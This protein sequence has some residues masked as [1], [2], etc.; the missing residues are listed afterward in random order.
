VD[1][2]RIAAC[3][4]VTAMLIAGFAWHAFLESL[5]TDLKLQELKTE[6]LHA[7]LQDELLQRQGLLEKRLLGEIAKVTA[8]VKQLDN[9]ATT[10]LKA[11]KRQFDA[12]AAKEGA[13]AFVNQAA[14]TGRMF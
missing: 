10:E 11:M 13:H 9:A 5:K 8:D 4:C 7:T 14:T 12:L 3:C 1:E 2:L 6:Q